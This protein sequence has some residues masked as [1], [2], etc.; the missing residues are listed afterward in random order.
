M[1]QQTNLDVKKDVNVTVKQKIEIKLPKN[2]RVMLHNNDSTSFECVML[3]LAMIFSKRGQEATN[4]MFEAHNNGIAQVAIY[5]KDIAEQKIK[6]FYEYKLKL[7]EEHPGE[8]AELLEYSTEEA[9]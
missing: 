3:S 2:Y 1:A 4:I 6:E 8:S 7:I 5:T 9:D